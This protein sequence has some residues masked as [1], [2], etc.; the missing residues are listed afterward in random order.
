MKKILTLFIA[1]AM[2]VSLMAQN[3]DLKL[4]LEKGKVYRLKSVSNQNVS[5]T[6]NGME[7]TTTVNSSSFVSIKMMDAAAD[8]IIAEVKFDSINTTTNTMGKSTK[9]NS[10]SVGNIASEDAGEVM[11]NV[12]NRLCKN[13]IYAKMYPNGNVFEIVNLAMLK[14]ILL[15]DTGAINPKVGPVLKT[16]INGYLNPE[17]L[18]TMINT[19]TYNL[20]AKQVKVGEQW[21]ITVP[22]NMGG[23][24]MD[25]I[26][27]YKLNG[28]KDN[29][30]DVALESSIKASANAAP[31]EYPGA[32]ITY[33]G[34]TGMSKAS[35]KINTQ[36][37]LATE[38]TAK[39]TIS[40]DL[41]VNAGGMSMQ[42]PMKVTAE[43]TITSL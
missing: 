3:A 30:A 37:G 23:M 2:G 42:I 20:P 31:M 8:F 19:F 11:S 40:G 22:L 29:V 15:K 24:S 1:T 38:N 18:K 4:K 9:I 43:S 25:I 28:I 14:D 13:P 12:M 34:L 41:G 33:D 6:I 39:T 35:V 16:Q 36:T 5:Q 26:S 27:N 7:Q 21:N 32:K 10:N 17:A